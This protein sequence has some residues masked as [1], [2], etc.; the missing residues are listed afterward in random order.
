[1][2][3]DLK[4]ANVL[5]TTDR[6][7]KLTDFGLAKY[8]GARGPGASE[9]AGQTQVGQILGTPSYM[10]PEQA[11]GKNSAIGPLT[12]VYAL[13]AILY[14]LLTGRP[15]F[16][17]TTCRETLEQVCSQEPVP[18]G[19][20]QPRLSRDLDTICLKCLQKEPVKRYATA[21][22]LADDLGRFLTGE[23]IR[24][25]PVTRIERL[26]RWCRRKPAVAS[27]LGALVLVIASG[28]AVVL[29]LWLVAEQRGVALQQEKDEVDRQRKRAD[30]R[31][32]LARQAVEDMTKVAEDR[33]TT[34]PRMQELQRD[35]LLKA[36][37]FYE[38]L[39]QD[40]ESDPGLR[41]R[42]AQAYFFLARIQQRLGRL[43]E[44]EQLYRQQITWLKDLAQEFPDQRK[45]RFDL[46]Q[47][48][49]H[50]A[51]VLGGLG[52]TC[53]S[54][55]TQFQAFAL[56]EKLAVDFPDE[57]DYRDALANQG[58]TVGKIL[59]RQ[60]KL[61]A[62]EQ[63]YRQSLEVA[64]K[65]AREFP[66]K[67]TPPHYPKNV[68]LNLHGLGLVLVAKGQLDQAE[69]AFDKASRVMEE[70]AS[71]YPDE[72][73]YR[74]DLASTYLIKLVGLLMET[75]RLSEAEKLLDRCLALEEPLSQDYPS[76]PYYRSVLAGIH[77]NRGDVYQALGRD[78]DAAQAFRLCAMLL[79]Q[80][81]DELP[82]SAASCNN[83]FLLAM[84][85]ANCP[86]PSLRDPE[87][88]IK[89][90]S[91]AIEIEPQSELHYLT[92]GIAQYRAGDWKAC[93]AA[94]EKAP[95][96]PPTGSLTTWFFQS[97]AYWQLGDKERAQKAYDRAVQWMDEHCPRD[98]VLCRLRAEAADLLGLPG[99]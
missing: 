7:P 46:F 55:E 12:D 91:S 69:V 54:E 61:E 6:I 96:D 16:K 74:H 73:G 67:R 84:L 57:P 63:I 39:A 75:G 70:L 80:L 81:V 29:S 11:A 65:L 85:L 2:H 36:L 37:N 5:V 10:A 59:C 24:A 88:A 23:P 31:Q 89:L 76:V 17:G 9:D 13:G 48:Y 3:R 83:R 87:R 49:V 53:E 15:P 4:P 72:F 45:Y 97:M 66:R 98:V 1:M 78:D 27:L 52:R 50:Q 33:L 42:T 71:D 94:L 35:I 20:L 77:D 56:I 93:I 79:Q 90:A 64:E 30:T 68:A 86:L 25:R 62:A 95:E 58:A 82:A 44:A 8:V 26:Y 28:F 22:D 19:R 43:R 99:P 34:E 40:D 41:F 21:L 60:R 38:E 51:P 32:R 92:L 14:E 47:S 18:P